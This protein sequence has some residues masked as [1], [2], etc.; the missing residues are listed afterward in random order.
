MAHPA[1]LTKICK[2]LGSVIY[3]GADKKG[4]GVCKYLFFG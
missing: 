2:G 3:Q 1:S 4:V